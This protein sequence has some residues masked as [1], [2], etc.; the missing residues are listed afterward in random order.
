MSTHDLRKWLETHRWRVCYQGKL[1]PRRYAALHDLLKELPNTN[2][3][4]W[5]IVAPNG[6][7]V[8][9]ELLQ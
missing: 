7:K 2:S 1:L 5:M 6:V 3:K 8:Q 4:N 9:P